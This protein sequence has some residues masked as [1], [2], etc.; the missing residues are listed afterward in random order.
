MWWTNVTRVQL[1]AWDVAK[2]K[3]YY[4]KMY[5]PLGMV[6]HAVTPALWEAEARG[7]QVGAL[8]GQ[9]R[10]LIRKTLCQN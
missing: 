5:L 4:V 1:I 7:L 3:T 6:L 2:E 8:Y 9:F 10:D